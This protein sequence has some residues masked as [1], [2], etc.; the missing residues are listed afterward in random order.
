LAIRGRKYALSTDGGPLGD[1]TEDETLEGDG[2]FIGPPQGANK[3]RYLWAYDT[4]KNIVAM[5][6]VSDGNEKVWGTASQMSSKIVA[7]DRKQQL[8]RVSNAEFRIISAEMM[9]REDASLASMQDYLETMKDEATRRLDKLVADYADEKVVPVLLRR[10][11]DL[12]RGVVPFDFKAR[13]GTPP[14]IVERQMA[15]SI[16]SQTFKQLMSRDDVEGWLASKG[17][18]T[19]LVDSQAVGWAMDDAYE[20]AAKYLP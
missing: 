12:E 15:G 16:L 6:R 11:G 20:A 10:L 13:P 17:F 2:R 9:R 14:E 7:L 19:S 1:R 3:W 5:W 4:D 8:N 18:D